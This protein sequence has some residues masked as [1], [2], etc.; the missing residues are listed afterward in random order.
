MLQDFKSVSEHFT[1]L[2]IKCMVKTAIFKRLLYLNLISQT[3]ISKTAMKYWHFSVAK[4]LR[5]LEF[6]FA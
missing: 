5:E 1:T 4:I 2:R 3:L 6:L